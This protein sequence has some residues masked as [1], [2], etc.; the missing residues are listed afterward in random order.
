[1]RDALLVARFEILR[2]VRTWRALALFVVYA[3]AAAGAT[4]MF[5]AFV[6]V[7]E[8]N[9]AYQLG[10]MPTETPGAMLDQLVESDSW[11]DVVKEIVGSEHLVEH[12]LRVPPLAM[13]DL[14]FSFLV[15][16]FFAASAAAEC[17]AIDVRSRAI[18]YEAARTGRL[19]L[20]FGRFLGQVAL[21]AI[22]TVLAAVVVWVTAWFTMVVADPLL[23]LGWLLSFVPRSLA[24][25]LPFVGMGVAA[26]QL[27][28]SPAWARVI[29][30]AGI[31]SSWVVYGFARSSGTEWW[32]PLAD[33]ALQVLPQG[34]LRGLWEP[35]AAWLLA[36][37]ACAALTLTILT[38]GHLRFATR[39]L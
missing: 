17:I 36:A 18:R 15:V 35:G 21:T 20:A 1:L 7:M 26:S 10:V 9:V 8:N 16:P 22:A 34:W 19:E 23:L 30:F 12:V 3:V 6:G 33:V 29:A 14:W 4:W 31:A 28:A 27:T 32:A 37:G 5:A 24:F 2:A 25:A 39:D 38:A 13:F 11:R